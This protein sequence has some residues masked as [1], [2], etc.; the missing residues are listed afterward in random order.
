MSIAEQTSGRPVSPERLAE[1]GVWIARLHGGERDHALEKGFNH[2]LHAH[3]ENAQAFELTTEVWDE[4][5][6]LRRVVPF[7]SSAP[8][9]KHMPLRL[10]WAG[11]LLVV[12][13][14]VA[15]LY[16]SNLDRVSTDV[17]EQRM[18]TLDDGT[19]VFLNTATRIKINFNPNQRTV[20]LETGEALF[21]VAR[22]RDRPFVVLAGDRQVHALGT[23]FVVR[24]ES[25]RLAVTLVEGKVA[26]APTGST[27]P[28]R[29]AKT[30]RQPQVAA[31]E[32]VFTLTAGQRLTLVTGA[33]PRVDTPVLDKAIAWRRGQVVLDDTRLSQAI[34]EMNRYSPKKLTIE[35]AQTERL[36]INGLFQAGDSLS[37]ANAVAQTYGLRVAE[38]GDEIVITGRPAAAEPASI[39]H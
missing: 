10:A 30:G 39:R 28:G 9:A 22:H 8:P 23:S 38:Q 4:A 36:L 37:F 16:Y 6:N 20:V 25:R 12:I 7:A 21:D 33:P 2:W 15:G 34:A 27:A 35:Q 1:A 14:V 11:A 13:A 18:L 32:Q 3:P 31:R 24:R 26:V 19:R 5:P 29:L 17:G